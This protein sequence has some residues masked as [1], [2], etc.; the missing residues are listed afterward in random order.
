[1]GTV[2]VVTLAVIAITAVGILISLAVWV[3]LKGHSLR[4]GAVAG[5]AVL[6]L[7]LSNLFDDAAWLHLPTTFLYESGFLPHPWQRIAAACTALVLIIIGLLVLN[8]AGVVD[9]L[10][11]RLDRRGL[12]GSRQ[13]SDEW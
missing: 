6:V 7:A 12:N 10:V 11:R 9:W 2:I 1:M 4:A 3:G 13:P 8:R 5:V